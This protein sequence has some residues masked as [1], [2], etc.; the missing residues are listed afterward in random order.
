MGTPSSSRRLSGTRV[1]VAGAGLAGL[2]AAFALECDGADVT[3]VDA[4]DRVG[5]RVWTIREGFA[6]RQHA[7]AG[8]DIIEA[9][10][11]GVL[12]LARELGLKTVPILR[13]GFGYYGSRPDGR[14]AVQSI[15]RAFAPVWRPLERLVADYR[16]A[17]QRWDSGVAA[18][19]ARQSVA[20]WLN[21]IGAAPWVLQRFRGFRGLFLADPED[22]SLLALIDFLAGEPFGDGAPPR[23]LA[24]GNDG[25]AS[26]LARR[27]GR[28]PQLETIVRRIRQRLGGVT[29]TVERRGVRQQIEAEFCVATMPAS[30]LRDV[31]FEP[32]LP[33]RQWGAI[34]GLRYGAATRALLQ[35]DR[36]FWRRQGRPNAF[37]SDQPHGAVW[38]GNEHQRGQAG[39]LSL[40]AG[41]GAAAE[42]AHLIDDEG[43]DGL[44]RRLA[45]LGSPARLLW[46]RVVAWDRDPWARGGYAYFEAGFD[47]RSRDLL[48]RPVGRMLFAGEHTHVRWQG[49]MNGAVESGRRAAAEVVA[50]TA[51]LGQG[52]SAR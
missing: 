2:S 37:G 3:V 49:Y 32:G 43:M 51:M 33:E 38:D 9:E 20:A 40:L 47:P 29:I 5:G 25:L 36:P 28:R 39:I 17:E 35:F 24:G 50:L 27:L 34:I 8:A 12:T 6:A 31:R 46:S 52:G 19:L 22:L 45:W 10:Q 23:R 7:E 30:T 4:R 21:G 44:V 18:N 14:L 1:L 15:A 11:T 42:L 41:G 48:A 26:A 16:L 13:R